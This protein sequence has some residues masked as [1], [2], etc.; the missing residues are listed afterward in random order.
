MPLEEFENGTPPCHAQMPDLLKLGFKDAG[1]E[2]NLRRVEYQGE[3]FEEGILESIVDTGRKN[4]GICAGTGEPLDGG[5]GSI[6]LNDGAGRFARGGNRTAAGEL[7][8]RLGSSAR[9]CGALEGGQGRG[10]RRAKYRPD[11]AP[12]LFPKF[13]VRTQSSYTRSG[14]FPAERVHFGS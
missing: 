5:K 11:S 10:G 8:A 9:G 7:G 1:T 14:G 2:P 13:E 6:A 12:C 3:I 4:A